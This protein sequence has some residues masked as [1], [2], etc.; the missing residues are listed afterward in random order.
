M[1]P[2][3][4]MNPSSSR[5][6]TN[7]Q[8][9]L[10]GATVDPFGNEGGKPVQGPD[11]VERYSQS[12]TLPIQM[13]SQTLMNRRQTN[14]REEAMGTVSTRYMPRL[15]VSMQKFRQGLDQM[16]RGKRVLPGQ[17]MLPTLFSSSFGQ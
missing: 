2:F 4:R 16:M 14:M 17:M 15:E 6:Q 7:L 10:P 8:L 12:P 13:M 11:W 3:K 9:S 1:I 5:L